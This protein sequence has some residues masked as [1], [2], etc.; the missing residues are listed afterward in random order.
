MLIRQRPDLT[1]NDVTPPVHFADRRRLILQAATLLGGSWLGRAA[2]AT[3][4]EL[5]GSAF[6]KLPEGDKLTPLAEITS[7]N[8]YA[9]FSSDKKAVRILAQALTL[10]PWSISVEGEVEAPFTVDLQDLTK[11]FATE[12]RI[13]RF[14]CVEGWSM[15]VPWSGFSL[16]QLLARARPTSRA[17]YVQFISL[18]RA[19]EMIS[20]RPGSMPWPYREA[21]RIDE[22]MHPLT[23]AVTGLYGRPL[24]KQNGAPL[25]I[26]VP[27]KYGFKSPKAIT[28]IRLLAEQ[29]INFWQQLSASEYGFFGNVNPD[30]PHPRWSQSRENRIGELRKR[31]TLYLNGYAEQVAHLYQGADA[32][33]LY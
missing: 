29:P 17:K 31:P 11:L 25:R 24:P 9:E 4:R 20:Q 8:N 16:C 7:Y 5:P 23:M 33:S 15:V 18:K 3:P 30:V 2:Q 26:V 28:H 14:R 19:S 21:L 1:E 12:E 6:G 27:W 32:R 10:D 13:Y 22:A